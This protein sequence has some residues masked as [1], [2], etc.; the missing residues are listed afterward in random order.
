MEKLLLKPMEAAEILSIGRGRMYE[1]LNMPGF[2][3]VRLGERSIR[4][5]LAGLQKWIAEQGNGTR[6]SED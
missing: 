5:P 3:V 6:E 4:V 2:P 1:L